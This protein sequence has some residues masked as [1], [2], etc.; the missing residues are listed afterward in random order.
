MKHILL[1]TIASVVLVGCGP[2]APDISID[3]AAHDGNI[4]AVKQH[5]AAGTDVNAP[6][7]SG[8]NPL[9]NATFLGHKEIVE[10]LIAKGADLNAKD[11]SGSTPLRSAAIYDH[12]EIAE[13]L[14]AEGADV[15]AKNQLGR[16]SLHAAASWGHKEVAELLIAKGADLNAM[17]VTGGTPLDSAERAI[18]YLPEF[19]ERSEDKIKAEK[20]ET[21]DLL[22][23]HG[24]KTGEEL[25]AAGKPAEPVAEAAQPEPP[26]AKTPLWKAAMF[27]EI[28]PAKQAIADGADVNAKGE[29]GLTPLHFAV[30]A[31]L[32]SGDNKV[33]ELLIANGADVNAKDDSGLTPLDSVKRLS[34]V[35]AITKKLRAI[36]GKTDDIPVADLLRKHGGKTGEELKAEVK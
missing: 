26:T 34:E 20:K 32:D 12:K 22:R 18:I 1:T 25:E 36:Q 21:A 3:R 4:E 27:G 14:I 2:S 23:K 19:Y 30:V 31:A 24:G 11:R 15:N 16:T 9:H 10:L 7:G 28:E 29:R 35:A 13:I 5:L 8:W 33:I 17:H 6:D